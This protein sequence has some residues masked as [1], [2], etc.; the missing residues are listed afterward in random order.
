MLVLSSFLGIVIGDVLWLQ[1]LKLLGARLTILMTTLQPM[2]A[3]LAGAIF[4]KQPLSLSAAAGI[5]AV[6][7]GLALEQEPRVLAAPGTQS[8]GRPIVQ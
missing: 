1:A 7:A 3:A 4:L 6:C 5:V 8:T 2:I